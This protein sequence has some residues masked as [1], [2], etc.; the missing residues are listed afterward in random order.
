MNISSIQ[1]KL[2]TDHLDI[3]SLAGNK[4]LSQD[5]KIAEAS[6]QFEA[7]L[8]RQF[9]SESQK[10]VFKSEFT[11]N[12]TASGIYQDMISTQLAD[13]LSHGK[14]IG[15]AQVFEQQLTPHHTQ[16]TKK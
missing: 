14:G 11:D 8:V 5:Q 6:R 2:N 4:S 16:L 15:L 9:L 1:P 7:I 10:T 12:S 3:E 13:S